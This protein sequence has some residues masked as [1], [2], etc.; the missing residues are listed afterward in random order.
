M[1]RN[2]GGSDGRVPFSFIRRE[3]SRKMDESKNGPRRS[4][5]RRSFFFF[6]PLVVAEYRVFLFCFFFEV[7]PFFFWVV[8]VSLRSNDSVSFS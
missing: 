8:L 1:T 6:C 5:T 7:R 4:I 2:A 3:K